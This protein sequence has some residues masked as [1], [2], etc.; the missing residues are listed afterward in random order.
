MII[1]SWILTTQ[2]YL[3]PFMKE[4]NLTDGQFN[5]R[6]VH[7]Y[8]FDPEQRVPLMAFLCRVMSDKGGALE[9]NL[10]TDFHSLNNIFSK[11]EPSFIK[12]DLAAIADRLQR[13]PE[14]RLKESLNKINLTA[15]KEVKAGEVLIFGH[16][17]VPFVNK[18]EN[19]ANTGSWVKD[20]AIHNTYVELSDGKPRLFV[21]GGHEITDRTE[22]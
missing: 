15:C 17:H 11:F 22:P 8:Q 2:N 13:R 3:F 7:G 1:M 12:A 14:D 9:N 21:F 18:T 20:A 4:L 16:T 5:Y 10:W 6:F 19:V